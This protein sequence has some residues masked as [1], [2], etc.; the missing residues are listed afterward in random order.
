MIRYENVH[1]VFG[2][3]DVLEGHQLSRFPPA[4]WCAF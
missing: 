1:K 3:V 4:R 2:T